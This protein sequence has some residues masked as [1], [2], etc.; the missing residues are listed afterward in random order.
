MTPSNSNY[1]SNYYFCNKSSNGMDKI[2]I[3]KPVFCGK[4]MYICDRT[5]GIEFLGLMLMA[6][7]FQ[8]F[9]FVRSVQT[10]AMFLLMKHIIAKTDESCRVCV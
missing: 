1:H 6:G 7:M 10:A 5:E 2:E 9:F 4:Y 8:S 3:N